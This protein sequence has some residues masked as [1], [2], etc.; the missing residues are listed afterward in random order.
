MA[1]VTARVKGMRKR[2]QRLYTRRQQE[3]AAA[4]QSRAA[5]PAAAP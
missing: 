3:D 1:G 2:A 4:A 5:A